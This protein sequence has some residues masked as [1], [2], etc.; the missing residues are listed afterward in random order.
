MEPALPP[1]S[2]AAGDGPPLPALIAILASV[3][4]VT[5]D[6]SI[7]NTALPT[8]A[9]D[10]ATTD[11]SSVWIINVYHLAMTAALLPLAALGE[12]VGHR[13]VFL[14][15]LVVFTA[16]SLACGLSGA[17]PI[18]MIARSFQG[19]GAAAIS[20]VTPALIR[21]LY[22]PRNLGRGL[23]IYAAVV[24]VAFTVG[25][26]AASAILSVANWPWLFLVNV[27]IGVVASAL[28]L[29]R[30]P[31]TPLSART[32]DG[33]AA[34]LC[35]AFF[36]LLLLGLGEAAHQASWPLIVASLFAAALCGYSLFRREAGRP[37]PIL[38]VDLFRN[39][40]FA[41]SSATSVCA[42]TVQ[43]C[44][45]VALPFLLH[46]TLGYDQIE[47]GL[48]ITPWPAVVAVMA[49]ITGML[50]DRVP[51]GLLGGAGL[52]LLCGGMASL[53]LLPAAP[54]IGNLG[55]RLAFCGVGFGLFQ[56]PNMRSIMSSSPPD[57]SGSASGIVAI[58]RMLGQAI[59]AVLVAL[60]FSLSPA[61]GA[62]AALWVGCVGA[63]LGSA[64]SFARLLPG[65]RRQDVRAA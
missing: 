35:A 22:P 30:L 40:I 58:S 4:T 26:T 5:L 52:L 55:L 36:G 50:A 38:A 1:N 46:S 63:L 2:A 3:A 51:A 37:A 39:P 23:G 24:G 6:I 32:L 19:L 7:A 48:L 65:S 57:R 17:L 56:S 28:A 64:A 15:G 21:F 20:G 9:R 45:F 54:G 42:F 61:N 60:C 47:V 33:W 53:A 43:G 18:L 41:L 31:A 16:A 8:I 29:R 11:A 59:G 14:V 44:A 13:R 25:P 34:L 49:V 27:P 10:L 12:I 62:E